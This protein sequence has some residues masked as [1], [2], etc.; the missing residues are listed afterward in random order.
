MEIV[1]HSIRCFTSVLELPDLRFSDYFV[2]IR[3]K[4][5]QILKRNNEK[6]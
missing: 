4:R 3:M 6:A 2:L 5:K 1:V